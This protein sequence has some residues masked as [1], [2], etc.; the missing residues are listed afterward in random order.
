MTKFLRQIKPIVFVLVH[1]IALPHKFEMFCRIKTQLFWLRFG[2]KPGGK[3]YFSRDVD[4][5]IKDW[6][7][8]PIYI[9]IEV[10]KWLIFYSYWLALWVSPP[11][12]LVS[13]VDINFGFF[14]IIL[15][16]WVL[17]L[18]ELDSRYEVEVKKNK[19]YKLYVVNK[20]NWQQIYREKKF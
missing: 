1:L 9:S 5:G 19:D 12:L 3:K 16:L 13:I 15:L 20:I 11:L 10:F 6:I 7:L 14:G 8:V 17:F 18:R 2:F 4:F